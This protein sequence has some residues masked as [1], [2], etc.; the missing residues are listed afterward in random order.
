MYACIQ[1]DLPDGALLVE[2]DEDEITSDSAPSFPADTDIHMPLTTTNGSHK[3]SFFEQRKK[4]K[5]RH[6]TGY[7]SVIAVIFEK[8]ILLLVLFPV[9]VPCLYLWS[10]V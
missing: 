1:S 10:D 5:G 9:C 8:K 7:F 6:S 3:S 2:V 4:E